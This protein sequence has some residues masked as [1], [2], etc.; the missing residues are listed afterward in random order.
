MSTDGATFGA[1]SFSQ[2]YAPPPG[3]VSL[4]AFPWA[5]VSSQPSCF[6]NATLAFQSCVSTRRW[7]ILVTAIS[8][9][10]CAARHPI[11]HD[12]PGTL[13]ARIGGSTDES[14]DVPAARRHGGTAAPDRASPRRGRRG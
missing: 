4:P 8:I 10:P 2:M 14:R 3:G 6:Q 9:P 11:D 7:W 12:R 13:V 1:T 5:S